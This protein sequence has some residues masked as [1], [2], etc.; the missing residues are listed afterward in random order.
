M[1]NFFSL[2]MIFLIYKE[3]GLQISSFCIGKLIIL[4]FFMLFVSVY[5]CQVNVAV[6]TLTEI[7]SKWKGISWTSRGGMVCNVVGYKYC[8]FE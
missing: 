3:K 2:V 5:L 8:R 7:V 1:E 4:N 6:K